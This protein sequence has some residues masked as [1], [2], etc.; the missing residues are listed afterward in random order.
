VEDL[1]AANRKSA[2]IRKKQKLLARYNKEGKKIDK[3][4]L[5]EAL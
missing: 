1:E 2:L 3:E 5:E 4:K